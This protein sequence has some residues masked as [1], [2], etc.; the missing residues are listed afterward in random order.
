MLDL[1]EYRSAAESFIAALDTE[2]FRHFSGQKTTYEAAAVFDRYPELFS[3]EVA[4]G[5]QQRRVAADGDERVRL[6]YLTA[7]A[8]EGLLG[9][10][11]KMLTD[12]VANVERN[13]SISVDGE[14][15]GLRQAGMAQAN[16]PSAAKRGR[17]QA[18]RLAATREHLNP[19]LQ[20]QWHRCH[21][22]AAEL[23]YASYKDLF[24]SIRGIDYDILRADLEHFLDDTEVMFE[25]AMDAL[26]RERL[27][28]G[29]HELDYAD[30]PRL[31]RAPV[32]DDVFAA[33]GLVPTL[34]ATLS[35]LGIDL[36]AQ[37]N[38]HLDTEIRDSKSP[39]PFCAPV[40]VPDEI[41][42]VVLPQGGQDDYGALL[43][44]AGHAEHLAHTA[45]SLAFEYRYLGD[46]AVS[47]AFAFAF[48]HL[49]T[50][51]EWQRIVMR[52][53]EPEAYLRFASL[54][55]L[56]LLR[57]HAAKLAYEMILHDGGTSFQAASAEYSR[58]LG[59]ATLVEVPSENYL[60]D[61]DEGFYCAN[62]LRAW[63]LE[64]TLSDE[65]EARYGSRWFLNPDAGARLKGLWSHGQRFC[66]ED[67]LSTLGGMKLTTE[68]LCRR[69]KRAL[70]AEE[71]TFQ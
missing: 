33:E 44:E 12:E 50:N 7:F 53:E 34:R 18:A 49:L 61:V 41:H 66:A 3:R 48:D 43:H 19:L 38:V 14:T 56:Y 2:Y 42:L 58:L 5:L 54:S 11:T 70:G 24:A 35:G 20:R 46:I 37:A 23:G 36:D 8:V 62:Y 21:E 6:S 40:R 63:M 29:L 64:C 32:F 30:L 4:A 1:G 65:M 57:R 47:E 26:A 67:V 69:F 10:Q 15:I 22:V 51:A 55:N 71:T 45:P 39:R 60:I 25:H 17:I 28:V 31:W 68:P 27:G 52:N 59:A 16:E 9:E 13:L